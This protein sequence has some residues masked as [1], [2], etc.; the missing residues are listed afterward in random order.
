MTPDANAAGAEIH[1]YRLAVG[2]SWE[3]PFQI[4][5]DRDLTQCIHPAMPSFWSGEAMVMGPDAQ[6]SDKH[7]T[8]QGE[9]GMEA[10]IVLELDA[11]DRRRVVTWKLHWDEECQRYYD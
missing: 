1:R 2:E 3:E 10:E 7:W 11:V 9:D 5:V 6:G 8:I 4:A